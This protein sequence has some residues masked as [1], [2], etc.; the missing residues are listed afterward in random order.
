MKPAELA[1]LRLETQRISATTFTDPAEVVAWL[2]AVQAQD[3]LG[4]LWAVGLRL[5]RAREQDVERALADR[6]IV[7]TWPMRGTLHFV[8][9]ADARWLVDLLGPRAIAGA[10]GRFRALE[11]DD[12]TVARARRVLA[13]RLEAGTPITRGAAYD[14]LERAKISTAGQRGI[15]IL[16]RLA[17][18]RL[19]CFGPREGKQQ[20]FVLFDAWLP[21]ARALPSEE[22][23][24][25]LACRY[26]TGH[27][28]AAVADFAWWSGLKVSDA[29]RAVALAGGRLQRVLAGGRPYWCGHAPAPPPAARGRAHLL[30]AFDE[31]VVAYADRTAAVAPA[32]QVHV[33]AGGGILNPTIVIDGRVAGTWKRRLSRREVV[34]APA[35]FGALGAAKSRA[36]ATAL[37]R[38]AAFLGL[39]ARTQS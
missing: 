3:Y 15:H 24:G 19:I 12:A 8:A 21:R 1:R 10:A 25:E 28:P 17:H 9:A 13:K 4:A 5:A 37:E 11:L 18:E 39:Q 2:G 27:G 6:R 33:N 35:P 31:F 29:H 14:Q 38:Y 34:F 30:P 32:H 16:W 36:V 7:R 26:F 22:A 20:T 23:L